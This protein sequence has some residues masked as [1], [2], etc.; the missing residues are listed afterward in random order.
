[1]RSNSIFLLLITLASHITLS[2]YD[3]TVE[4]I[5]YL[6][7]QR[8]SAGQLVYNNNC[9]SCHGAACIRGQP[10]WQTRT[11][12]GYL[13]APPHDETGHT[14]HHPD[15]M[16]FDYTKYG[17]QRFA[18]ANYKSA[19]PAYEGGRPTKRSGMCWLSSNRNGPKKFKK[20][21]QRPFLKT[22]LLPTALLIFIS[23]KHERAVVV[24]SPIQQSLSSR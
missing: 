16:L 12:T 8:I 19:M 22:N 15:Q 3:T 17:P 6:D 18:G 13:P 7:G 5:P 9:A 2:G 14:W 23:I 21:T 1:M 4:G 24:A 11:S 20:N 10:D